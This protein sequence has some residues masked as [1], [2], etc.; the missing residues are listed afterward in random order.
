MHLAAGGAIIWT[1][2]DDKVKR[3]LTTVLCAGSRQGPASW[4]CG[5]VNAF[6]VAAPPDGDSCRRYFTPVLA[7][8]DYGGFWRAVYRDGDRCV[9]YSRLTGGDEA[10]TLG[11]LK[12]PRP[13]RKGA[14][15]CHA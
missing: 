12:Y 4:L 13:S 8:D 5:V 15:P 11:R 3:R 14:E 9:G 6:E 2:T 1:M 10:G 7:V